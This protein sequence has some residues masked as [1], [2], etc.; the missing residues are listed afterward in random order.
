MRKRA[1]VE[2]F[3]RLPEMRLRSSAAKRINNEDDYDNPS[4]SLNGMIA[5][6]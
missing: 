5:S 6:K 1:K 3:R 4:K 2:I